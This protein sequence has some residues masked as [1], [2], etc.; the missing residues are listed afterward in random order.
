[1]NAKSKP[2]SSDLNKVDSHIITSDE[3]EEIPEVTPEMFAQAVVHNGLP[4]RPTKKQIALRIDE[5]VLDW[6]RSQGRGWQTRMN[7]LLRA[8][9]EAHQ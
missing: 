4:E 6:F 3:Y 9:M 8:Y 1:M 7:A 5:D 2:I